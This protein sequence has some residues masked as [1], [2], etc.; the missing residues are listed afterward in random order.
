MERLYLCFE[1][2]WNDEAGQY[3]DVLAGGTANLRRSPTD[4][5]GL[6]VSSLL[7]GSRCRLVTT[8][9]AELLQLSHAAPGLA[10]GHHE[11]AIENGETSGGTIVRWVGQ[12][13][14]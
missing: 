9:S 12:W 10:S 4:S 6:Q 8:C 3:A 14:P 7:L 2:E 5:M 11:M 13:S 1:S